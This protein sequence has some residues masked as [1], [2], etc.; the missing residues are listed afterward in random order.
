MLREVVIVSHARHRAMSILRR[1]IASDIRDPTDL[2]LATRPAPR[3][4]EVD[5][6]WRVQRLANKY[7]DREVQINWRAI[8][9][10]GNVLR[11]DYHETYPT[12]LWDTCQKDSKPFKDAVVRIGAAIAGTK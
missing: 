9:G 2:R 10:I 3:A 7:K 4:G 1:W 6:Q 8:A 11:H 12:I 5:A